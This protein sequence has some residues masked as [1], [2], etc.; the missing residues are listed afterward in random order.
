[1]TPDFGV[2]NAEL[3]TPTPS[4][5]TKNAATTT[6]ASSEKPSTLK[7]TIK[8]VEWTFEKDSGNWKHK[9]LGGDSGDLP[10]ELIQPVGMDTS[11]Q[12]WSEHCFVVVQKQ[13]SSGG[14]S[15]QEEFVHSIFGP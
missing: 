15:S 8:H 1:M 14:E 9:D 2:G 7:L 6:Y 11:D 4:L 12:S 10:A 3:S 5:P 13:P